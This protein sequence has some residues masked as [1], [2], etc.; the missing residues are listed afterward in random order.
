MLLL[1]QMEPTQTQQLNLV[2]L[3][4]PL[5]PLVVQSAIAVIAQQVFISM[6]QLQHA[7]I[8]VLLEQLEH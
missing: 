7:P 4:H 2:Q 1:A 5:V 6:L 3:A 8:T